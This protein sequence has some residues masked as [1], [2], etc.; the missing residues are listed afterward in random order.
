VIAAIDENKKS[1]KSQLAVSGSDDCPVRLLVLPGME[2]GPDSF[3]RA[4]PETAVAIVH[5]SVIEER[6]Q[7]SIREN[8]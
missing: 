3:R 2:P 5:C 7:S 1:D 8:R 6:F 4:R